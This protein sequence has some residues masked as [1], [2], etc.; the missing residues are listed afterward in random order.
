[1]SKKILL[2]QRFFPNFREGLFDKLSEKSRFLL[3]CSKKSHKKIVV[4]M[5]LEKKKYWKNTFSLRLGDHVVFPFLFFSLVKAKPD[6]IVTE[7]GGNTI[8][9]ISVLLYCALFSK[10]F[11]LWDLGKSHMPKRSGFVCFVYHKIYSYIVR[12]ADKIFTYN[13]LGKAYFE[14]ILSNKKSAIFVVPNTVDTSLIQ[15]TIDAGV[16]RDSYLLDI[17]RKEFDIRLLYVGSLDSNKSLEKFGV[18]IESILK[19]NRNP[20][21]IIVGGGDAAYINSL[22]KH[23]G[24]YSDRIFFTGRKEIS[25]LH[26][27]YAY[28]NFFV[29]PGLGGLAIHQS[30][31]FG[32]PVIA[33]RADGSEG[34]LIIDGKTGFVLD[35]PSDV[36]KLIDEQ[37]L[38]KI[39]SMRKNCR[40]LIKDHYSIDNYVNTFLSFIEV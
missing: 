30:M 40:K 6:S 38:E 3:L 17:M 5:D 22:Q 11:I 9:N 20:C 23:L 25:C 34:E 33:F 21:L 28:A 27:Y 37:V 35:D 10:K 24:N 8:N 39:G 19:T 36:G 14:K 26:A 32:L 4:P 18:V 29:L 2:V 7:G 13:S 15:Q 31:A 16:K 12:K 1:M